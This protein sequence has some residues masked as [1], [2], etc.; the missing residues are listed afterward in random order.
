[1]DRCKLV[2]DLC[3]E[4]DG[5]LILLIWYDNSAYVH[6][7]AALK[8][9]LRMLHD[10]VRTNPMLTCPLAHPRQQLIICCAASQCCIGS[11][12]QGPVLCCILSAHADVGKVFPGVAKRLQAG[13]ATPPCCRIAC[14]RADCWA[15]GLQSSSAR[16][17]GAVAPSRGSCI[18]KAPG[19]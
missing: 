10:T 7:I 11:R 8:P 1:M 19:L 13:W 12:Q 6:L 4:F 18:R 5:M 3:H 2:C 16:P 17:R 14:I 15:V 9:E